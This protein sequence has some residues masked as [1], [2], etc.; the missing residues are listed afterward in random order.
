MAVA[1]NTSAKKMIVEDVDEHHLTAVVK[2]FFASGACMVQIVRLP[3]YDGYCVQG[4]TANRTVKLSSRK[5]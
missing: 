5:G 1:V 4:F 3:R 2:H